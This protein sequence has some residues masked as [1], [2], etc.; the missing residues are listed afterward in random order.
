MD[1]YCV[2]GMKVTTS[3]G[4]YNCPR[5]LRQY[6]VRGKQININMYQEACERM[7]LCDITTMHYNAQEEDK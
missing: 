6:N 7:M 1:K 5:C 2:C 4:G 3:T